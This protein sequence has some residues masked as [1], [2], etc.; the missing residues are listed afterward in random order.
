M[1]ANCDK[2][3]AESF[4]FPC[5]DGYCLDCFKSLH[6]K[7]KKQAHPETSIPRCHAC[8]YQA[9]SR[10]LVGANKTKRKS[11]HSRKSKNR[12][13]TQFCD[14]CYGHKR[15]TELREAEEKDKR[16]PPIAEW[17]IQPCAECEERSCR[18]K[19]T[20]CD[21]F[22]CTKC[23]S[24]VHARGN[25]ATHSYT[26]LSYYTVEMERARMNSVRER[27]FALQEKERL[28]IEKDNKDRAVEKISLWGQSRWR[29]IKGR[30]YGLPYLKKGRAEMRRMYR[31]KKT[32]DILRKKIVYKMQDAIGAAKILE[33][34][35]PRT[36]ARKKR[37]CLHDPKANITHRL[38][39]AVV[40][41]LPK[42]M[43]GKI[44]PGTAICR[45]GESECET[46]VDLSSL[47]K[48]GDRIRVGMGIFTIPT[49]G[50][51]REPDIDLD[52]MDSTF[53]GGDVDPDTGL[54]KADPPRMNHMFIPLGRAWPTPTQEDLKMYKL[55]SRRPG[56]DQ[57]ATSALGKA[58]GKVQY[59]VSDES[60]PKQLYVAA[61]AGSQSV[62]AKVSTKIGSTTGGPYVKKMGIFWTKTA[63][64]NASRAVIPTITI[65][66][67]E[68]DRRLWKE[69]MDD[70]TGNAFY[71][72]KL[73][74]VVTWEKPFSMMNMY[75]RREFKAKE[76]EEQARL[77]EIK[78][79][80][81]NAE[82]KKK[83]REIAKKAQQRRKRR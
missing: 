26:M 44:L 33:S 38:Q 18:W 23:F 7:G 76:A 82:M 8:L 42:W 49:E 60:A 63:L 32:D 28:R 52:N 80:K 81:A 9:A 83:E 21:D 61:K 53:N 78:A 72:N 3:V 25:R 55:N 62:I 20:D 56:S 16:P 41:E 35:T 74:S 59:M 75:E 67:L 45:L 40:F 4:C 58:W 50:G 77:D 29:G 46:S 39:A 1:C 48:R 11:L 22:Y 57:P 54:V 17:M 68:L 31:V 13:K 34:D 5:G 15:V 10:R 2:A 12:P 24:H 69:T 6:R 79:Q 19:C 37:A 73:T 30:E 36:V 47:L 64:M 71:T 51:F 70:D 66:A 27:K 65:P 43:E 14:S